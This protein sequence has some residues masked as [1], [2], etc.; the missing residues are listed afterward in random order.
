MQYKDLIFSSYLIIVDEKPLDETAF[1]KVF[2]IDKE[3]ETNNNETNYTITV[4]KVDNFA[5]FYIQY[6][7]PL[8][9]PEN[10]RN[11]ETHQS[12]ENPRQPNQYEPKQEFGLIHFNNSVLWLSNSKKKNFFIDLLKAR[13]ETTNVIIKNVYSEEEFINSIKNVEEIKFSAMPNLFSQTNTLSKEL[14]E[15]IL[16]Y[17]AS[18][19]TLIMRFTNQSVGI[20]ILSR[21]KNLLSNKTTYRSLV[22]TGRDADNFGIIFNNEFLSKRIPL[23]GKV[24]DNEIYDVENVFSQLISALKNA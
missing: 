16:G 13:F 11:T 20:N 2:S 3:F 10:V 1:N 8:P 22:I 5:R 4:S 17:G 6:G 14:S 12:E 15:E 18:I 7:N 19:A 24:N 21:I 23:K 9:R